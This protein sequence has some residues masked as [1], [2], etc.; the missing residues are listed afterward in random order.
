VD[1]ARIVR[2][3]ARLYAALAALGG[4][5]LLALVALLISAF[6]AKDVYDPKFLSFI[7]IAGIL[8]IA[9]APFIWRGRVWAMFAALAIA[10][11]LTFLFSRQS[12]T[13]QVVLPSTAAVFAL[14]TGI[15]T[16]LGD[17]A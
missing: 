13:L 3:V 8:P 4:L 11:G 7:L 9:L 15:R 10:I 17:P 6:G 12:S 1:H 16:W 14:F 2:L 5:L